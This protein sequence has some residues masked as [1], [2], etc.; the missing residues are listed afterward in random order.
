MILEQIG[1]QVDNVICKRACMH[2]CLQIQYIPTYSLCTHI[3][4]VVYIHYY[5]RQQ[6]EYNSRPHDNQTPLVQVMRIYLHMHT[7][8]CL[9]DYLF[10]FKSNGMFIYYICHRTLYVVE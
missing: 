4:F 2:A 10:I 6:L 1:R 8:T 5:C 3:Q 9:V 7:F